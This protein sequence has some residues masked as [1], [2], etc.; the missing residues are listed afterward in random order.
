MSYM[1]TH[2]SVETVEPTIF[3]LAQRIIS[4]C[5]CYRREQ[6]RLQQNADVRDLQH[7]GIL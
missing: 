4:L 5:V 6:N 7:V 2:L 3:L 1:K